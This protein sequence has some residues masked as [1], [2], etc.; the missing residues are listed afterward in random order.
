MVYWL[1]LLFFSLIPSLKN[2][3]APPECWDDRLGAYLVQIPEIS[4]QLLR[5]FVDRAY[6][7]LTDPG[8]VVELEID[9]E[10][11]AVLSIESENA[12]KTHQHRAE[13]AGLVTIATFNY[14]C[15]CFA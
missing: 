9:Q 12:F 4:T 14:F 13:T 10:I 11:A 15:F 5:D 2:L 3:L 7:K 8:E 6:Q 1:Y